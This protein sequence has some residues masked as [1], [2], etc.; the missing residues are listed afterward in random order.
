MPKPNI[1]VTI[2]VPPAL[3]NGRGIPTIGKIPVVIAIFTK[4]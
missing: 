4:T 2:D 3:I 1:I